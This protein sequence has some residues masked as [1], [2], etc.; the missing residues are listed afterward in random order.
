M[1]RI[2]FLFLPMIVGG[3]ALLLHAVNGGGGGGGITCTTTPGATV[4]DGS[5]SATAKFTPSN[6]VVTVLLAN[7]LVDPKSAGQLLSGVSFTL[8]SGIT[9]GTLGATS[10]NLRKVARDG[11]FTDLGPASTGWELAE[12]FN[13]GFQLCVLCTDLGAAGPKHLLIGNPALSGTYGSANGSIAGNRPHNPFT[14]GI[15]TFLINIPGLTSSDT[16][17]SATFF[18]GTTEGI[19]VQGSCQ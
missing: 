16:V 14:Q 11:S 4:P 3:A 5:V 1:R 10:A 17:T 18:F 13:G 9:T 19:S 8:A 12:N 15:A 2:K 7:T 6:G